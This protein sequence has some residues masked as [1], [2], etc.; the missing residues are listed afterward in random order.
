[1]SAD[2][3]W[4]PMSPAPMIAIVSSESS[5]Y[6]LNFSQFL[7]QKKEKKTKPVIFR[8]YLGRGEDTGRMT[9]KMVKIAKYRMKLLKGLKIRI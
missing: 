6:V 7:W 2:I 8:R 5:R 4:H 9:E 1:M 3:P